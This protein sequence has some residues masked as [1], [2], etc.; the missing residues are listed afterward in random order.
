MATDIAFVVGVLTLLGPR[1]PAGLKILLLSLAI[2][3]DVGGVLVIAFAFSHGV[4][5]LMLA[6]AAAGL[7]L[8]ALMRRLGFRGMLAYVVVSSRWASGWRSSAR[9]CTRRWP[10]WRWAS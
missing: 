7:A 8:V 3:D 1:V 10:A 4:Q 9:G 5:V 6:L 2:A